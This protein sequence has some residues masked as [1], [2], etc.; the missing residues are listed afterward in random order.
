[1]SCLLRWSIQGFVACSLCALFL[2]ADVARGSSPIPIGLNAFSANSKDNSGGWF[3]TYTY[4]TTAPTVTFRSAATKY[5]SFI[6]LDIGTPD[7]AGMV[8]TWSLNSAAGG[9]K[10][11]FDLLTND[12]V[13]ADLDSNTG[14]PATDYFPLIDQAMGGSMFDPSQYQLEV[15]YKPYFTN[16]SNVASNFNQAPF[17]NVVFEQFDGIQE[18]STGYGKRWAEQIGYQIGTAPGA[19][20]LVGDYN[21]DG[22]VD[23]GD[24]TTWRDAATAGA[25]TLPN[26]DGANMGTVSEADFLSWRNNYGATG[27]G[28]QT[29]N[30]IWASQTGGTDANKYATVV[31]PMTATPTFYGRSYLWGDPNTNGDFVLSGQNEREQSADFGDF[32][33]SAIPLPNGVVQ[34]HLQSAQAGDWADETLAIEVKS[35]R[36]KRINPDPLL[37]ARIDGESG[38]S[39]RFDGAFERPA[40]PININGTNYV[41][42]YTDQISRFGETSTSVGNLVLNGSDNQETEG[43]VFA[44]WGLTDQQKFNGNNAVVQL[45]AKRLPGNTTE[46]LTVVLKDL[47]GGDTT[48]DATL[49][50]GAD[51][52]SFNFDLTTLPQDNLGVDDFGIIS[53]PLTMFTRTACADCGTGQFTHAGD[54]DISDFNLYWLGGQ[55]A[56]G[57][58]LRTHLEI[59][60]LQVVLNPPSGS[61]A[62][63]GAA[64]VPEP[65]SVIL[66]LCAA[67]LFGFRRRVG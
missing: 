56:G 20:T 43:G 50:N 37:V 63:S 51:Q 12:Y 41:P 18:D 1:M 55:V 21:N 60:Y 15:E 22:Q 48:G 14:N 42:Q 23:A 4:G 25:T 66:A 13:K 26:R 62:G 44:S 29:I 40:T 2:T 24:Y 16:L 46:T 6:F 45:K 65:S 11:P 17:F 19:G 57:E 8:S 28:G 27:G 34:I 9:Y 52:Y 32:E 3:P 35:I 33:G 47:D 61:G 58:G 53:I 31:I 49:G 59:E 39:L 64:A 30:E 67:C 7:G 5:D 54:N 38:V 10:S 36:I